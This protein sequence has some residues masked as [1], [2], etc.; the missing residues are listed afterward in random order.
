MRKCEDCESRRATAKNKC[1][2]CNSYF[3]RTKTIRPKTLP[4]KKINSHEICKVCQ[5]RETDIRGRCDRCYRYFIKTK[6]E[7]PKNTK[8]AGS[9]KGC[10]RKDGYRSVLINGKRRLE[11]SV[12]ME[13]KLGRPLLKTEQVHHINGIRSDNRIENLE[14]WT[15]SQPSGQRVEDKIKWCKEFISQYDGFI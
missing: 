4:D 8:Y 13:E 7:R 9:G 1:R 11:H 3:K 2:R 5:E 12:M 15:T 6:K 14:L 10:L